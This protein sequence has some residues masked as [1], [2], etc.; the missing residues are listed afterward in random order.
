MISSSSG[1]ICHPS[2]LS[3]LCAF[4]LKSIPLIPENKC[5]VLEESIMIAILFS[6]QTAASLLPDQVLS[7]L[8][9]RE[10]SGRRSGA[11]RGGK[12]FPQGCIAKNYVT[13]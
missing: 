11:V 9:E 4:V 8:N 10:G 6:S 1:T 3:A 7:C 5:I 13:R 2:F 12:T